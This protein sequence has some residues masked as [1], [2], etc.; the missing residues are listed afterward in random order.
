[1]GPD[2]RLAAD[3]VAALASA[4]CNEAAARQLLVEAGMSRARQPGWGSGSALGFW[5]EVAQLV[6]HGAVVDGRRQLLAKA[7]VWYPGN[8]V[9]RGA[10]RTSDDSTAF[11]LCPSLGLLPALP[12]RFVGRDDDVAAVRGLLTKTVGQVVGVVGMGG[13]GKSTLA[14]AVVHDPA[15]RE[16]F[17][18][19][20][21]WVEVNPAP[22]LT[23]IVAQ[24]L[25]A[26]GDRAPVLDLG[27][28]SERLR[29]LLDGAACLVVLDNVW[30]VDVLR[31]LP[32]TG[33]SRLLVTTRSR[34]ALFTDSQVH[35]LGQVDA[36]LSQ[37]LLAS[38][39]GLPVASLPPEA[40]TVAARCGGLVLALALAGGMIAE[41]RPWA[42]VA[43]RLQRTD[44]TRL[45]GRFA[46]YPHLNL[47]AALDVSVSALDTETADRFRELAVFEGRG[48]VPSAVAV[49]LWQAT[50][51]LDDLDAD[52]L[53]RMLARRSLV[54]LDPH[55]D[56]FT[57]HDLLLDHARSG[58]PSG[59]LAQLHLT[60]CQAFLERWGRLDRALPALRA[61]DG[62][63]VADRYGAAHLVAHLLDADRADVLDA[64]LCAEWPAAPGRADNAWFTVH[65]NLGTTAV[66]LANFR[67]A[68]SHAQKAD[69]VVYGE[70]NDTTGR[71]IHYAL[72]LGSVAS[73]AENIPPA[74]LVRAV[75][76]QLW[77][78]RRALAYAESVPA[79][80]ARAEALAA[81]SPYL[82]ADQ[83]EQVQA[84]ATASVRAAAA[85]ESHVLASALARLVPHLPVDLLPAAVAA[86]RSVVNAAHRSAVLRELAAH[87]PPDGRQ[88]VVEEA[89]TAASAVD[90]P[91]LRARAL[92]QVAPLLPAERRGQVLEQALAAATAVSETRFRAEALAELAPHLPPD[93]IVEAV[94]AVDLF[95]DGFSRALAWAGLAPHLPED[96][97][98]PSLAE[99]LTACMNLDDP[100]FQARALA[101]LAPYLPADLLSDALATGIAFD[102]SY[103]VGWAVAGLTPYLPPDRLREAVAAVLAIDDHLVQGQTLAKVAPYLP[104]DL[105]TDALDAAIAME[106]PFIRTLTLQGLSPCLPADLVAVA[107]AAAV[108]VTSPSSRAKALTALALHLPAEYG[109][110]TLAEAQS[111]ALAVHSP[112]ARA[113]GLAALAPHLPEDVLTDALSLALAER[114]FFGQGALAA[115]AP[116][117]PDHL[118]RHGFAVVTAIDNP[119][120]RGALLAQLAPCLPADLVSQ[121]MTAVTTIDNLALRMRVLADL[122]QPP[123]AH[124]LKQALDEA[125]AD[126]D[127]YFRAQTLKHLAPLLPPDLLADAL[128]V[129]V[130]PADNPSWRAYAFVQLAPHL[131]PALL[132]KALA[133]TLSTD[134]EPSRVMMLKAIVP[135]LPSNLLANALTARFEDP[136]SRAAVLVAASTRGK[137]VDGLTSIEIWHSALQAAAQSGR[138]LVLTCILGRIA[139][140]E[141][142]LLAMQTR[143]SLKA[144]ERWWP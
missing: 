97:P 49:L 138:D 73:I 114:T 86:G 82:S 3:E 53:L 121:A 47:L 33:A 38:Y 85:T 134:D 59:Q 81:L 21:L 129:A 35:P 69:L 141:D 18:G 103:A 90:N 76:E 10:V 29:R 110:R 107:L 16:A 142:T 83:H 143:D 25:R 95:D 52:E 4:F 108:R 111:A 28:G 56:T 136:S 36:D 71:M 24:I 98:G 120:R 99:A 137:S 115:L 88:Q 78:P 66:C 74:L 55:S 72:R 133:A 106:D 42:N 92:A 91:H 87:V 17:P 31:A 80:T 22:D 34:D 84:E 37:R 20:L 116:H 64:V 40:E 13:A 105:L 19:G 41:G 140:A 139:H 125:A 7:S 46:D 8:S 30:Q 128:T 68:L 112:T 124:D 32:V 6:E 77:E 130:A 61:V 1:M 14:R 39:A 58:L 43:E 2:A 131:P 54:Q 62:L 48:Q 93:L 75:E 101:W 127:V 118:L 113:H 126:D 109:T 135:H 23:A 5:H 67:A 132:T 79:A 15:V 100:P 89:L 70:N 27:D 51:G 144:V 9:F 65:E 104:P 96:I 11:R 57:I 44:R 26:F 102:Q 12:A 63:A 94:A 123:T 119:H 122:G 117:L 50:A 45:S 60:L